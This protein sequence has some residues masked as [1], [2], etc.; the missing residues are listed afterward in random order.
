MFHF[1]RKLFYKCNYKYISIFYVKNCNIISLEKIE[2]TPC[3]FHN[4]IFDV[5]VFFE[6]EYFTFI[7]LKNFQKL[8]QLFCTQISAYD[9]LKYTFV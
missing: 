6:D 7:L 8:V 2:I 5:R 1:C 4:S 9:W 3:T